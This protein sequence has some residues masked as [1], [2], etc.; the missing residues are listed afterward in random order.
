LASPVGAAGAWVFVLGVILCCFGFWWGALLIAV[1]ALELWIA[2]RLL[3][4]AGPAR[5]VNC[6]AN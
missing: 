2:Y 4:N 3:H 6:G 5:S 1:G